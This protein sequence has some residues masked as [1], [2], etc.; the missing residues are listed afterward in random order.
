MVFFHLKL[1]PPRPDFPLGAS[2]KELAVMAEHAD[3][4]RASADTGVAVAVGPVF[5]PAGTFGIAIVEV[6]DAKQAEQL[7]DEDPV[8]LSELGFRYE[9]SPIP[10]MI[11]RDPPAALAPINPDR[12]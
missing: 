7:A 2:E 10:S 6:E 8:V 1:L 11:L 9:V 5:D 12:T 4:W 3:Y